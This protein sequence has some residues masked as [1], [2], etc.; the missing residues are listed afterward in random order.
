MS[1]SRHCSNILEINNLVSEK[2][3]FG[4]KFQ[5]RGPVAL[6]LWWHG[7]SHWEHVAEEACPLWWPGSERLGKGQVPNTPCEV[8]PSDMISSL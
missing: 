6:N 3:Y 1:V 5:S 4:S 7:P 8:T 2:V